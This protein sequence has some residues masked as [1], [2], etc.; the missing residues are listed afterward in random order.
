[1]DQQKVDQYIKAMSLN[2]SEKVKCELNE[3][4]NVNQ[5]YFPP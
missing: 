5:V 2:G 3:D 1:M 4:F